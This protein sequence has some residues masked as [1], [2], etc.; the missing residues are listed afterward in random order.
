MNA[1]F[2]NV[3][4]QERENILDQH[5]HLYDGYVTKYNQESNQYPLYVQD[6]ANDKMGITVNSRGDVKKY[7]NFNINE[8][9]LNRIGDGPNDLKHGTFDSEQIPDTFNNNLEYFHNVYSS[10]S[11]NEFDDEMEN[12]ENQYEYDIDELEDFST[13]EI[14]EGFDKKIFYEI[15]E[16]LIDEFKNQLNESFDMFN[17]FKNYN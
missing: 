8:S 10:P 11:E 17:R 1:Y 15:D 9:P 3:S 7:T 2:F 4:K 12:N 13:E 14:T 6:L 16:D 5:K